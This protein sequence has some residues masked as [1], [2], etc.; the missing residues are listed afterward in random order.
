MTNEHAPHPTRRTRQRGRAAPF[1]A[2]VAALNDRGV[3]LADTRLLQQALV[4]TSFLNEHPERVAGG[5]SNER[6]EFLGDSVVNMLTADWLYRTYPD[7]NEGELTT[8]RAAL[9]KTA[10]L[11]HFGQQLDL[12]SY[13][14]ISRGE[15]TDGARA[16]AGLL[17][18]VFEAVL[19][20]IYLTSGLEMARTLL[21][22]LLLHEV[23]RIT[24][25]TASIDYRTRLQERVQAQQSITPSYRTIAVS[26]PDHRRQFTV[27]VSIGDKQAGRGQ[28]TSKQSAA[29]AAAR[30]ALEKMDA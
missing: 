7:R 8:L 28:G 24:S 29:Q 25:G 18:D 23:A 4:H 30:N 27:E 10:T 6:L 16:R 14:C 15:D 21:E 2:F 5:R 26:G 12:G 17:A 19:A 3:Q 9:V 1:A 22:P 13:V 20:A 11:A